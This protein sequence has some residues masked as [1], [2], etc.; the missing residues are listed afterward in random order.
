M[1]HGDSN[2]PNRPNQAPT[3]R[4]V[5]IV[6]HGIYSA[7]LDARI[8]LTIIG[9]RSSRSCHYN[10]R[11]GKVEARK[12]WSY[13]SLL[14]EIDVVQ[15]TAHGRPV[16]TRWSDSVVLMTGSIRQYKRT[17]DDRYTAAQS[18][19]CAGPTISPHDP[20]RPLPDTPNPH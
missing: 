6:L 5:S 11:Q 3:L 8:P 20:T 1:K 10:G 4:P 15:C 2:V 16:E 19:H 18:L 13:S 14:V 17:D 9:T 7:S 12:L